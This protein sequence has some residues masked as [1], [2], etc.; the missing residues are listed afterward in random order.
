LAFRMVE[1]YGSND[2]KHGVTTTRRFDKAPRWQSWSAVAILTGTIAAVGYYTTKALE[3]SDYPPMEAGLAGDQQ[4]R[5]G[6]T[7]D[8]AQ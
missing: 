4:D 1:L 6:R 7:G 2:P 8:Q 5:D 3:R